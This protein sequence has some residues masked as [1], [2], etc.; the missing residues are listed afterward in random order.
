V[1]HGRV[2]LDVD[3][4]KEILFFGSFNLADSF[5]NDLELVGPVSGVDPGTHVK[6]VVVAAFWVIVEGGR[7]SGGFVAV[8]G[9]VNEECFYFFTEILYVGVHLFE[10]HTVEH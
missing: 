9:V 6:S 4:H 8:V 7:Q 1:G 3:L 2:N 5:I 10:D